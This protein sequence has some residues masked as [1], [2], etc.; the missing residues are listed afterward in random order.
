MKQK[1][2]DSPAL[3]FKKPPHVLILEARFYDDVNDLMIAGV[4]CALK[5][6]CSTLEK[7]SVTGAIEIPASLQFHALGKKVSN[8]DAFLVLG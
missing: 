5:K 1:K 2:T 4:M 7:V 8:F 3:R 6:I